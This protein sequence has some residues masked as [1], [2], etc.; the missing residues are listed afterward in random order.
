MDESDT[1]ALVFIVAL[2]LHKH[3]MNPQF[4][5]DTIICIE[6]FFDSDSPFDSSISL[7]ITLDRPP[8]PY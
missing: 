8:A 2:G 6:E 4:I 1:Q 3:T 5:F 7:T